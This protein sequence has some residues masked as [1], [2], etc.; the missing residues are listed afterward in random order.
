MQ[1]I[2]WRPRIATAVVDAKPPVIVLRVKDKRETIVDLSYVE[3][4]VR[5]RN[6]Q[7]LTRPD[8]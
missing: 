7:N 8:A 5:Q 6:H 1:Q 3:L 4:K 2:K